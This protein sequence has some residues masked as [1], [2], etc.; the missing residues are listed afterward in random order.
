MGTPPAPTGVTATVAPGPGV[1]SGEVHLDWDVLPVGPAAISGYVI[2]FTADGDTQ[3]TV[4][5]A[6]LTTTT[7]TV[8]GL[9]NGT[10]YSFRIAALNV[11]GAGP[12]SAT[13]QATPLWSPDAPAD[14]TGVVAPTDGVRAGQVKLT[15][16]APSSNGAP[17]TDYVIESSADGVTWTEVGDFESTTTTFTVAGLTNGTP[18]RFRVAALNGL[19]QGPWSEIEATPAA[20]PTRRAG[21]TVALAPVAGIRSGQAKLAWTAPSSNGSAITDYVI[22]RSGDGTQWTTVHDG[23]SPAS[24]DHV[25]R[26]INGTRYYVRIAGRNAVGV[27]DWSTP[28]VVTPRWKPAAP[29]GLR[30]RWPGRSGWIPPGEADVIAPAAAGRRSPTT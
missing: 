2:R 22:Q 10:P 20:A 18:Y 11:L 1:G 13:V 15:W 26:L 14:L 30:R 24:R 23:M 9:T 3:E 6:D 28:V 19:G 8:D 12:W 25:A 29:S 21:L 5:D 27:G 4:V 7:F 17:I 16:S